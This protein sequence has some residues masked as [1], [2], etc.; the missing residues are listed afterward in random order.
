MKRRQLLTTAAFAIL[1]AGPVFAD[2]I[3]DAKAVVDKYASKV[4]K[5]DGPTTGP[6][7]AADKSVVIVA[8]DMKNGGILGVVN[9]IEEAA[10]AMGWKVNVLDSAGSVEGRTASFGQALTL[11]P[12]GIIIAGFD[13]VE[14]K[15][16]MAEAKKAK[17]P[18]V[19]WHAAPGVGPVDEVGVFANVTTDAME[20]PRRQPITLLS[21]QAASPASSFSRTPPML[22]RLPR[23]TR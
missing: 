9:G 16:A 5:W 13:A 18:M 20:V 2:A 7:A 10:K 15:P 12:N 22:S 6:K 19:A 17:I 4:E 11:K 21:M 8:A 23:P 14:Q 3:T 1:M